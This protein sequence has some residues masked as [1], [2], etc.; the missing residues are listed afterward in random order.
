MTHTCEAYGRQVFV[1]G[2]RREWTDNSTARCS[3]TPVLLYDTVLRTQMGG[4]FVRGLMHPRKSS[5]LTYKAGQR[6]RL[7]A[8]RHPRPRHRRFA[9]P[10]KMGERVSEEPLCCRISALDVHSYSHSSE[11]S[12][13]HR[14]NPQ[15]RQT[16]R[17]YSRRCCWRCC[18]TC[19]G[20]VSQPSLPTSAVC[21]IGGECVY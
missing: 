6:T 12:A 18:R 14:G 9:V 1:I 5:L 19:L 13:V 10:V 8:H 4:F 2:G 21:T 15:R 17:R 16:S 20:Y 3:D 7:S 11:F